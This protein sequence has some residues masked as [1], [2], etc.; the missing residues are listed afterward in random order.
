[1]G[2]LETGQFPYPAEFPKPDPERTALQE[3]L[4]K[5]SPQATIVKQKNTDTCQPALKEALM[6]A[7][8]EAVIISR[9]SGYIGLY[10]P[11]FMRETMRSEFDKFELNMWIGQPSNER[12]DLKDILTA[13]ELTAV[14][15]ALKSGYQLPNKQP[16]PSVSITVAGKTFNFS[17]I[18]K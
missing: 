7:G 8:P 5:I 3:T 4:G 16:E 1:M 12:S 2:C 17:S 9:H 18:E 10:L 11:E 13:E 15:H 14:Q 6:K